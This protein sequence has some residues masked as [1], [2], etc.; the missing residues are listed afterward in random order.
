MKKI[1]ILSIDFYQKILYSTL[2]NLLGIDPNCRFDVTCS[3]YAKKSISDF[4]AVKGT[5]LS[6]VRLLKC[7]PFYKGK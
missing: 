1:L 5:K 7:Q 2:K 3:N 6:V 4:G